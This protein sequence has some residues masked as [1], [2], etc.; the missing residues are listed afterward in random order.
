LAA[1]S[2]PKSFAS[3][4]LRFQLPSESESD[5]LLVLEE[6]ALLGVES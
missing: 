6:A 4:T 5:E 3:M 1:I 2:N